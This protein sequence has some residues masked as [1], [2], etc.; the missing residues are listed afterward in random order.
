ML[1]E[2]QRHNGSSGSAND[3]ETATKQVLDLRTLVLEQQNVVR[4]MQLAAVNKSPLDGKHNVGRDP[5][6][7]PCHAAFM[8]FLEYESSAEL[9]EALPVEAYMN[10]MAEKKCREWRKRKCE[11][12]LEKTDLGEET[13]RREM[14]SGL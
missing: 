3:A 5:V 12:L 14:V 1:P 2:V 4:Q 13:S 6:D 7:S 8:V 10:F 9:K 11:S